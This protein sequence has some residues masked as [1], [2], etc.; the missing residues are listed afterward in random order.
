MCQ[1]R[2]KYNLDKILRTREINCRDGRILKLFPSL[3]YF[4][5]ANEGKIIYIKESLILKRYIITSI[6]VISLLI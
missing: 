2:K 3:F 1:I 6:H 4:F 5:G